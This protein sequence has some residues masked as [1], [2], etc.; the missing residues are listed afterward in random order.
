MFYPGRSAKD[1]RGH[2]LADMYGGPKQDGGTHDGVTSEL[3]QKFMLHT[4]KYINVYI[5]EMSP[6]HRGRDTIDN[7]V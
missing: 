7:L 2:I 5:R 1:T 4:H 6:T 3:T